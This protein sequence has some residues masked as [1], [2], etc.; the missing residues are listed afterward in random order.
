MKINKKMMMGEIVENWPKAAVIL[1]EKY[2]M[3][4]AGCPVARMETLENG[5]LAHGFS[6]KEIGK[7]VDELNKSRP[8]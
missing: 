6:Q 8:K 3:H 1:E 7:L 4:C 5:A 2:G